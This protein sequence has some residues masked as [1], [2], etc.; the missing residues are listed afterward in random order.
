VDR[1][2]SKIIINRFIFSLRID[3]TSRPRL[4]GVVSRGESQRG[5]GRNGTGELDNYSGSFRTL[6]LLTR[7]HS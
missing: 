6:F 5:R 1:V 4:R 3:A 2:R 7:P